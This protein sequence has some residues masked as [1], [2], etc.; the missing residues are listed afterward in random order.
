MGNTKI[1]CV[2]SGP[3]EALQRRGKGGGGGRGGE[4]E[5]RATVEVEVL[6]AGFAGVDRPRRKVGG[7]GPD[8][9][10]SFI[11]FSFIFLLFFWSV[12]LKGFGGRVCCCAGKGKERQEENKICKEYSPSTETEVLINGLFLSPPLQPEEEGRDAISVPDESPNSKP[13]C[14]QPSPPHY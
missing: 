3:S 7:R 5:N 4:D 9:Y 11:L 8:R 2:V 12:Y 10:V 14:R 13:R 6:M 1:L